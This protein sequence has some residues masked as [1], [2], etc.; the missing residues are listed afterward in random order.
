MPEDSDLPLWARATPFAEDRV[1]AEKELGQLAIQLRNSG[2]PVDALAKLCE[3][4]HRELFVRQQLI[5]DIEE[6]EAKPHFLI[7]FLQDDKI[8]ELGRTI[9]AVFRPTI[10][11]GEYENLGGVLVSW[12]ASVTSNLESQADW[13][14][15]NATRDNAVRTWI[16][17]LR[18]IRSNYAEDQVLAS[19]NNVLSRT[20]EIHDSVRLAAGQVSNDV[21]ATHFGE[22]AKEERS[23]AFWWT[24]VAMVF[25]IAALGIGVWIIASN[26]SKE[27]TSILAHLTLTLPALAISAYAA[28]ISSH[29]RTARLWA[30]TSAVQLLTVFAYTQQIVSE[31][32][33]EQL[34]VT[35][36]L[37]VFSAPDFDDKA[38]TD[39]V[40]I[41][42]ANVAET[43][44][45]LAQTLREKKA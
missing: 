41:V 12:L 7:E 14:F 36:G 27:W 2:Q 26:A 20:I 32:A 31:A 25:L 10:E 17:A 33:K 29:H 24:I 39:Q 3:D 13:G 30:R 21:L 5:L 18:T 6:G 11:K 1:L 28:R 16:A 4:L 22:L 15:A 38:G 19:A 34:F 8:R 44:K 40:S 42:P 45:E 35:L 37:R 23:R 9:Q 43:I